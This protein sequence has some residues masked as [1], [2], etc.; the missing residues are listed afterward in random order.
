MIKLN[1]VSE[2]LKKEIKLRRVYGIIKKI[3]FIFLFITIIY[4]VALLFSSMLIANSFEETVSQTTLITKNAQNYNNLIRD[5]NSRLS[6]ISEAQKSFIR[7][8]CFLK[9]LKTYS[10]SNILLDQI[11]FNREKSS[12][13]MRG[14]SKTRDELLNFKE[15]LDKSGFFLATDL[16]LKNLLIREDI[17]FEIT[18]SVILE[19]F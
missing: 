15:K 1:L 17:E 11:T 3:A 2:N 13:V 8:S 4:A 19:K 18:A 14:R 7:L 16:P 12:V 9:D 10:G 6:S 5:I